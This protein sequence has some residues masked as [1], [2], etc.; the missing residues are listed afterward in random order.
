MKE[1]RY[2]RPTRGHH[3]RM[4][5]DKKQGVQAERAIPRTKELPSWSHQNK[6]PWPLPLPLECFV[7]GTEDEKLSP[8]VSFRL[9]CAVLSLLDNCFLE[10]ASKVGDAADPPVCRSRP[11]LRKSDGFQTFFCV[12]ASRQFHSAPYAVGEGNVPPKLNKEVLAEKAHQPS[13]HFKAKMEGRPNAIPS[14]SA[15][16]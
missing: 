10:T 5:L 1:G 6:P 3:C 14:S 4:G 16:K 9:C 11:S 12:A 2:P 7:G 8:I 13:L 15:V